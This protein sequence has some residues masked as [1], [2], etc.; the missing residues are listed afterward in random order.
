VESKRCKDDRWRLVYKHSWGWFFKRVTVILLCATKMEC[1]EEAME[2][3]AR[4]E[5][6]EALW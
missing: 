2:L 4:F 6:A 5:I 1:V 3:L